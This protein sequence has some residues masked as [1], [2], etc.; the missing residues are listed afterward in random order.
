MLHYSYTLQGDQKLIKYIFFSINA[1]CMQ[2]HFCL[3]IHIKY[4][5]NINITNTQD[6]ILHQNLHKIAFFG[7]PCAQRL[8]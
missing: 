5:V 2:Q 1:I 8:F 3:D 4:F 7:K 6:A